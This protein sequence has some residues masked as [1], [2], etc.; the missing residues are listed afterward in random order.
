VGVGPSAAEKT[1]AAV[2]A[3]AVKLAGVGA[4]LVDVPATGGELIA[5]MSVGTISVYPGFAATLL[6]QNLAGEEPP[7]PEEVVATL[8]A[9]L[10]PDISL[11]QPNGLDGKLVWATGKTDIAD[12]E[13]AARAIGGESPLALVPKFAIT[14]SDGVPAIQAVYSAALDFQVEDN[15]FAR[16]ERAAGQD[17]FVAA[18]RALEVAELSGL[19]QLADTRGIAMADPVAVLF[20]KTLAEDQPEAIIKVNEAMKAL[21]AAEFAVLETQVASGADPLTV[22]AP[23]VAEKVK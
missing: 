14:R 4:E 6:E 17:A 9:K 3:E 20:T 22:A 19:K 23:W 2:C 11:L 8:A 13:A 1:L 7:A 5:Q 10:A 18:F 15:A 21:T 16:H 12:W